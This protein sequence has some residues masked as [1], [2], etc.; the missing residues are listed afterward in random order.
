MA[1]TVLELTSLVDAEKGD[2]WSGV[3]RYGD[4]T[5][6][7]SGGSGT[8]SLREGVVHGQVGPALP[9]PSLT[10]PATRD[11]PSVPKMRLSG[12]LAEMGE[13]NLQDSRQGWPIYWR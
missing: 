11:G 8:I 5:A 2:G 12:G 4:G 6:K 7:E 10:R 9:S 1:S 13:V 3:G